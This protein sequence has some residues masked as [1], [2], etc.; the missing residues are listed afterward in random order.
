MSKVEEVVTCQA[1]WTDIVMKVCIFLGTQKEA[2]TTPKKVRLEGD[3]IAMFVCL[4]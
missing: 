3:W 2:R 4:Y 1:R